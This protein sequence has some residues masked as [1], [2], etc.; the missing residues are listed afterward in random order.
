MYAVGFSTER[1]GSFVWVRTGV[2]GNER[3]EILAASRASKVKTLMMANGFQ[4]GSILED[5]K[6][7]ETAWLKMHEFGIKYGFWKKGRIRGRIRRISKNMH[8]P[9]FA[10]ETKHMWV[11]PD[12]SESIL[13]K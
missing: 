2:E 11:Y 13:N 8:F 1:I 6:R 3:A 10:E 7:Y 9:T 4:Y 12:R 5:T